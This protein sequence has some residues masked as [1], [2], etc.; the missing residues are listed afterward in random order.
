MEAAFKTNQ[1]A[2]AFPDW[3][4]AR[5]SLSRISALRTL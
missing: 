5:K 1:E 4:R 3:R 2:G